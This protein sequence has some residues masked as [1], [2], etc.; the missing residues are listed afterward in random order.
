MQQRMIRVADVERLQ[1]TMEG[2][3]EQRV[4]EVTTMQA[5]RM[6]SPQI[7]G[8]QAKGYGLP[9]IAE[10]LSDNGVAVTAKTLKTYLSEVRAAGGRK[11][12]RKAK[13]HRP[14][15]AG[16]AATVPTTG[17]KPAVEPHAA[18]GD[19]RPGARMVAK[20]APAATTPPAPTAPVVTPK[21]TARSSDDASSRRSAFVPKEDTRDI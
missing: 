12:R 18:S 1:R 15:G 14:V 21:G 7:R 6:L 16:P 3:P 2:V 17:S 8:M 20:A 13:T 11:S 19:A 5:V 9:A 10:L 4:E